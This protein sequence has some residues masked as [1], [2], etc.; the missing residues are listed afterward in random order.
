VAR[1]KGQIREGVRYAWSTP[2]LR[3]PLLVMLGVF[4][5]AY[6]FQILMPLLA[7]RVF[8]GSSGT[9]GVMLAVVGIG[10]LVGAL[11]MASRARHP[12]PLRL[13][14]LAVALGISLVC[15]SLTPSFALA[16]V[17]LPVLG[18]AAIAFAI[19]GNSTLQLTSAPAMRG[20]PGQHADRRPAHRVVRPERR[21]APGTS[22]R[23]RRRDRGRHRR[24]CRA[25]TPKSRRRRSA[26]GAVRSDGALTR[27][28]TGTRPL[29]RRSTARVRY[30]PVRR[31]QEVP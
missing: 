16:L 2:D 30:A 26:A 22:G 12:N 18:A 13:S 24:A 7:T 1:G 17:V 19:T 27:A 25:P 20:L 28:R 8:G 14:V 23:G 5:F 3:L 31:A 29:P 21:D 11:F 9:Y 10:S 6:N 15:L 4:L